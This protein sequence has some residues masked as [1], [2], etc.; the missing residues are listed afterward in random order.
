MVP[1]RHPCPLYLLLTKRQVISYSCEGEG[2]LL[3]T[4][5]VCSSSNTFM[6]IQNLNLTS[7]LPLSLLLFFGVSHHI[8]KLNAQVLLGLFKYQILVTM[9]MA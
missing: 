1:Q 2:Y 7:Q 9:C 8:N 4:R 5:Y 3:L 6:S